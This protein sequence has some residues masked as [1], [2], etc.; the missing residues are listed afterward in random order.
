MIVDGSQIASLRAQ[1]RSWARSRTR[2]ELVRERLRGRLQACP[3]FVS[4][5]P[6]RYS[7]RCLPQDLP[8]LPTAPRS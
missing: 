4:Q 6:L 5:A 2:W 3:K 8:E 1:G 7:E